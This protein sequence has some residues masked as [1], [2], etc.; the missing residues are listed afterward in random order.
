MKTSVALHFV[1]FLVLS[2]LASGCAPVLKTPAVS[3]EQARAEA[4][5]QKELAF[6][7]YA[8]RE[9]RLMEA[10]MALLHAAWVFCPA[11]LG[12]TYGFIVHDRAAYDDFK[13]IADRYYSL[14]SSVKVKYVH[15]KLPAAMAGLAAG[16]RIVK[17][18]GGEI[19]GAEEVEKILKGPGEIS[20]TVERNGSI[21]EL[22]VTSVPSCAY[23]VVLVTNDAVNAF[24]DGSN[25]FITTAMM[26]FTESPQELAIVAAHEIAHNA[27][28]HITKKRGNILLGTLLDVLIYSTTGID[29]R[30][31]SQVGARAFSQ[32]FE[33]E[34]DYAGLYIAA[35]AGYEIKDA[36]LFWRRIGMEHPGAI[37]EDF[38][39]THPS[40]P[41]RFLSLEE[42][43]KEIEGKKERGEELAPE[44]KEKRPEKSR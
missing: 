1:R 28:G 27:F 43:V 30:V 25:V 23:D 39:S 14:G 20:L 5:R 34:A 13:D 26:R 21:K 31:F 40:T 42:T 7:V 12:S 11:D 17:I 8:K 2:A 22:K 35:R 32:E 29:P 16:D 10:A 15:P 3:E 33:T 24:A 41:R 44:K 19:T 6:S 38:T 36:P 37:E 9:E 18:N 4:G